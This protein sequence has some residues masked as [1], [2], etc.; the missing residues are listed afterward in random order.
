MQEGWAGLLKGHALGFY[1]PVRN[2]WRVKKDFCQL[3]N[4]TNQEQKA[5]GS[6]R[7]KGGRLIKQNRY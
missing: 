1:D 2:F 5:D 4:K 3:I 7:Q 6:D